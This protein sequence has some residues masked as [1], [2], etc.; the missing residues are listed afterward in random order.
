MQPDTGDVWR[1]G[2][3]QVIQPGGRGFAQEPAEPQLELGNQTFCCFSN[4]NIGKKAY[5]CR[6][7]FIFLTGSS[8]KLVNITAAQLDHFYG[9]L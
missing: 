1:K 7:E 3:L 6:S 8:F 9:D 4:L 5:F 2:S